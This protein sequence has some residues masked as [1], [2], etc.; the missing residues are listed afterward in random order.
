MS[1]FFRGIFVP[2]LGF[3]LFGAG[4][5]YAQEIVLREVEVKASKFPARL[6]PS[7]K[8]MQVIDR[9]TLEANLSKNLGELLQTQVGMNMVGARNAPGSNQELYFRGSNTGQVLVLVDGFPLFDPSQITQVVDWNLFSLAGL[10]RIEILRGGQSTLFGSGAVAGVINLIT[11]KPTQ[12]GQSGQLGWQAGAFGTR[13]LQAQWKAKVKGLGLRIQGR[14]YTTQGFSAAAAPASEPDGFKQNQVNAFVEK[15]WKEQHFLSLH[16]SSTRFFGDL[17]A[18]P[19][20]DEIDYTQKGKAFALQGRY[21]WMGKKVQHLVQWQWER[22]NRWYRNDSI[23]VLP[24][25]W[26]KFFEFAY[27]GENK[28]LEWNMKGQWGKQHLW[29]LGLSWQDW[30]TDQ[31]GEQQALSAIFLNDHWK[32]S[33]K[34]GLELGWR[35]NHSNDYGTQ[36]NYSLNPYVLLGKHRLFLNAYSAFKLP[37][38]FQRFSIYGNADL[39]AERSQTL[40]LGWQW[41]NHAWFHRWVGFRQGLNN[42]ILFQSLAQAPYG[43]YQNLEE[44]VIHGLEYEGSYRIKSF[45]FQGNYTYLQGSSLW[46][47]QGKRM[48]SDDLIRRP[49]HQWNLNVQYQGQS[50]WQAHIL[51][52]RIGARWDR[53]Y[54]EQTYQNQSVRMPA[55]DWLELGLHYR[56]TK[57]KLYWSALLRNALN[58]NKEEVYGY[59]L[60]PINVQIQVLWTLP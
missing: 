10:E 29:L 23:Q 1:V 12:Q 50:P 30:R 6:D 13:S 3:C 31:G 40:E 24:N 56:M 19:F 35:L 4:R 16:L 18:G 21:Q 48:R 20:Q 43:R 54:N 38:V 60:Q 39:K 36:A 46:K 2:L 34:A 51:W 7:G 58:Q 33:E 47:E 45:K 17:D 42:G 53:F 59:A 26:S 37:S 52:N 27:Q 55:Y 32:W 41:E 15:S 22:M 44:Q 5:A 28:G 57:P 14:H 49:S 25:A 9:A 8:V 11:Q